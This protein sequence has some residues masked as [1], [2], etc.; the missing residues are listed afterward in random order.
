MP[1]FKTF[2]VFCLLTG[3]AILP[4]PADML[5]EFKFQ[6]PDGRKTLDNT[7]TLGG[8]ATGIFARGTAAGASSAPE[9]EFTKDTPNPPANPWAYELPSTDG[10]HAMHL[11]LPDS[12]DKLRLASEGDEMTIAL[13]IKRNANPQRPA[14]LVGNFVG[15]TGI[16]SD[17][18]N[19]GW[20]FGFA[21]GS[22]NTYQEGQMLFMVGPITRTHPPD[23]GTIPAG[24]WAHVA[25]VYKADR[26]TDFYLNGVLIGSGGAFP[27][28][29]LTNTAEIRLGRNYYTS[30]P[31]NGA[32][33]N[34]QLFDAALSDDQ[35]AEL[36][37]TR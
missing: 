23:R 27:T 26:S 1:P 17:E 4:A 11:D 2:S 36:A 10:V 33:D 5:Y 7:G 21:D 22:T 32:I 12:T 20:S 8:D 13:W 31:L 16:V 30:G 24:E 28:P 15:E 35:I 34:V 18:P 6:K 3:L 14:G 9:G 25:V 37:K 19:T 29:A